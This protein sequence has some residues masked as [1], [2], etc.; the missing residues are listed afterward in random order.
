[1]KIYNVLLKGLKRPL[2]C[3]TYGLQVLDGLLEHITSAS[4][5]LDFIFEAFDTS[6]IIV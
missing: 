6:Y 5:S 1:M 4:K 2:M 3:I